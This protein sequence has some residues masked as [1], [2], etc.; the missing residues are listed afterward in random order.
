MEENLEKCTK[1]FVLIAGRNAKFRS[2]QIPAGL[3]IVETV[4]QREE[5]LEE[6]HGEGINSHLALST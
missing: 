2:S 4:G 6:A 5:A 1:Q 3:S